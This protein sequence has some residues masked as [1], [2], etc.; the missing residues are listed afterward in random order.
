[1]LRT[2]ALTLG[3]TFSQRLRGRLASCG[4]LPH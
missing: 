4:N 3:L 2:A 1:L